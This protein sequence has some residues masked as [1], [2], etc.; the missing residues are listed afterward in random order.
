MDLWQLAVFCR[1]VELKSFSRAARAVHISQPTVSGHVKELEER[2]GVRL[3][4]RLGREALPTQAGRIL[5]DYAQRLLALREEAQTA[6][7]QLQGKVCGS[8]LLGGSTIPGNYILPA[9][10]GRFHR[11][12]PQVRV[13]LAVADTAAITAEVAAGRLELAVVGAASE[14]HQIVQ[15]KLIEDRLRLIVPAGHRFA[16]RRSVRPEELAGEP[17]LV[18]ERGS[19]TLD[20]VRASLRGAGVEID[21]M[22]IAAE[23]GSTEAV[24]QAIKAGCG[25][26][27]LSTLAVSEELAR[28][29]LFALEIEGVALARSF[30]LTRHRRRSLSPL[31]ATFVGLLRAEAAAP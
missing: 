13:S 22:N 7:A 10:I 1:V 12:H 16:G 20:A 8:L 19:G 3:I 29:G 11:R 30:Y 4:D 26:S 23:L 28:G 14:R 25:V 18:R 9:L 21:E 5:Y 15:E 6:L 24:R 31:A 2:C 17:F 27:I